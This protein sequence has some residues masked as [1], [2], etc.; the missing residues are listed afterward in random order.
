LR[1]F[2]KDLQLHPQ[3]SV[4]ASVEPRIESETSSP[5]LP[6]VAV[7]VGAELARELASMR[8]DLMEMPG[9]VLQQAR[10]DADGRLLHAAK[11]LGEAIQHSARVLSEAFFPTQLGVLDKA[12]RALEMVSKANDRIGEAEEVSE[13]LR[14]KLQNLSDRLTKNADIT[15]TTPP[16]LFQGG[17]PNPDTRIFD[18]DDEG[19]RGVFSDV[20]DILN[21]GGDA[22]PRP[23]PTEDL[24]LNSE[25]EDFLDGLS[26]DE[27]CDVLEE[28]HEALQV[29]PVVQ[30][31]EAL[32]RVVS[33]QRADRHFW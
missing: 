18:S 21:S 28:R 19:Q 9:F 1:G 4:Q 13:E 31:Y 3:K 6:A 8:V 26:E 17:A 20:A 25:D 24:I 27:R 10:A 33:E 30:R 22:Y 7:A 15:S 2:K 29:L 32:L 11:D 16:W 5:A 12:E 14:K 23:N